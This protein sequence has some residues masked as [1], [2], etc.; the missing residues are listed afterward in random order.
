MNQSVEKHR[1][2]CAR[3]RGQK[4]YEETNPSFEHSAFPS[5]W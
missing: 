3:A 5:S 1:L 4:K 2:R